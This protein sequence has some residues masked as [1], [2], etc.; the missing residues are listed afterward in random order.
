MKK[1]ITSLT[2]LVVALMTMV[3]SV[4]AAS[5]NVQP[6]NIQTVKEGAE[7]TVTVNFAACKGITFDLTY[8]SANFEYVSSD[9]RV[10]VEADGKLTVGSLDVTGN[11]NLKSI[12]L[13]F[14]ALKDITATPK[15][16]AVTNMQLSGGTDLETTP[17][18]EL[19]ITPSQPKPSQDPTPT[20]PI[21]PIDPKDDGDDK[22]SDEKYI[23]DNGNEITEIAQAGTTYFVG[24]AIVLLVLVSGALAVKKIKK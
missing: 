14:K 20:N 22:D 6:S 5:V 10:N 13:K 17:S 21:D 3:G 8:D 24:A 12:T 4:N 11:G 19:V 23:D 15:A 2:I 7:V 18:A 9:A 16:F 1:I